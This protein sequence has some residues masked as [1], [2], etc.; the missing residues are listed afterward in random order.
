MADVVP[1]SDKLRDARET[2]LRCNLDALARGDIEGVVRSFL[3]PR[4]E[5]VGTGRVLEGA[6]ALRTYLEER[7]RAF[8][9]QRF[10][11]ICYHHSDRAVIAELWM[12]GTHSGEVHGVEATGKRFRVRMCSISEFEGDDLVNQRMYYDHGTVARQLA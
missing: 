8:P 4:M 6:D 9:D 7:R 10:E 11:V 3:H 1:I 2:V 12:S 5:L